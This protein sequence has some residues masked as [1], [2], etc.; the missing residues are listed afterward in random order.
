MPGYETVEFKTVDKVTLRG[1]LFP[2]ET[3]SLGVV[4]SPGFNAT[5]EMIGLPSTALA[6]QAAGITAL[7]Y[8]PRGVGTSDGTPRNNINPFQQVDDMSDALV[9]LSS[10]P[11]VDPRQGVGLWGFSLG[12]A[13][14]MTTGA[15][16]PRAKF[17]VAVCPGTETS[18]DLVKLRNVLLKA[19]KDRESRI[20][21][22]EP[23]YVP[24]LTKK[25]ESP[26]GWDPGFE[27][28]AIMRL[29]GQYDETD[30]L[31]AQLA[32]GHVNRTT[33]ATYRHML[34]WDVGQASKYLTQP[35]LFLLAE[36]DQVIPMER[37]MVHYEALKAPKRLHIE[38]G[39]KHMDILDSTKTSDSVNKVQVDFV[40]DAIAGKV[41]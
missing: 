5:K 11:S 36:H 18:Y 28:D 21:G 20:K 8:D 19:A 9:Y 41:V 15:V 14:A 37:Q 33:A 10:C 23:F 40:R 25:G 24:M 30:P 32:P 34:L 4:M 12:A 35:V 27:H 1:W 2:A 6:F 38:D 22:N 3:R 13:V 26:V 39:A 16:D 7:L 29:L 17:V 31:R